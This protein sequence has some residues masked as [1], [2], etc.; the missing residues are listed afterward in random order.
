MEVSYHILK[1]VAVISELD[2]KYHIDEDGN[3]TASIEGIKVS[4]F[5]DEYGHIDLVLVRCV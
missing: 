2:Y 1:K 5:V 3:G 4:F